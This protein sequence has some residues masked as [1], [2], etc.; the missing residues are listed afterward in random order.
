MNSIVFVW[1]LGLF[2]SLVLYFFGTDD[3]LFWSSQALFELEKWFYF[4]YDVILQQP[5]EF[6]K[7][8]AIALFVVFVLLVFIAKYRNIRVG[9]ITLA[10]IFSFL[11]FSIE[12][13]S[14]QA[15]LFALITALIGA[16]R[17]TGLLY[18]SK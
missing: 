12:T 9:F 1:I 14:N 5:L 13:E 18:R 4:F 17:I 3:I 2:L 8:S 7:S 15:W 11:F 6:I 10:L 16:F